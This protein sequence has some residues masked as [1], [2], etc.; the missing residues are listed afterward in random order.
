MG[1]II[2][3]FIQSMIAIFLG[4]SSIE[5]APNND[6]KVENQQISAFELY[7]TKN[8]PIFVASINKLGK[9]TNFCTKSKTHARKFKKISFSLPQQ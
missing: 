1:E 8:T 2:G 6:L 4:M 5:F 3:Q 9:S 7:D